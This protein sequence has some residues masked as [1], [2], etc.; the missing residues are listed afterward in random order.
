VDFQGIGCGGE[1]IPGV[2]GKVSRFRN[3]IDQQFDA[4]SLDKRYYIA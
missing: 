3:W 2:Y 1:N 4:E